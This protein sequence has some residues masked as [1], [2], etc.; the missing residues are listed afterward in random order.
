MNNGMND[1]SIPDTR[2]AWGVRTNPF[3]FRPSSDFVP[4]MFST[5]VQRGG[6]SL[7]TAQDL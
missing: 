1:F 3:R 5:Y 6:R 2:N 7:I 4:D